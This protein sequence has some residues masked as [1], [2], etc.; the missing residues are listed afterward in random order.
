MPNDFWEI[1]PWEKALWYVW[2]NFVVHDVHGPPES[3]S[4][5]FKFNS[6]SGSCVQQGNERKSLPKRGPNKQLTWDDLAGKGAAALPSWQ[7]TWRRSDLLRKPKSVIP[8]RP[9]DIR[10]ARPCAKYRLILLLPSYG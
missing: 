8:Q 2:A 9:N 6:V 5:T 10:L 4:R 3:P 7:L 1:G